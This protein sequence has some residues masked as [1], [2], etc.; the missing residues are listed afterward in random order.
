MEAAAHSLFLLLSRQDGPE[1]RQQLPQVEVSDAGLGADAVSALVVG[2]VGD[3]TC[4]VR[5][6]A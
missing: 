4:N 3:E 5:A 6:S 1:R 2:G